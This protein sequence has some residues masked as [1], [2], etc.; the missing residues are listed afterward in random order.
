MVP[1]PALARQE[2]GW[3]RLWQP[4][5][6]RLILPAL[7]TVILFSLAIFAIILPA[8]EENSLE[9]KREMIRELVHT[10]CD[11]L[12]FYERL[13]QEG[14]LT[15]A[16]AQQQARELLRGQRYGQDLKD[17]FWINDLHPRMIMHPYRPDLEGADISTYSDPEGKR[18]FVEFVEVA[19]AQGQGYVGYMWQ[20]MD[21]PRRI[22][23]KISYVQLFQPW[24]WIVGTGIYV[25]DVAAEITAMMSK[26]TA[27]SLT[28]LVT[29]FLLSLYIIKHGLDTEARRQ[30]ALEDLSASRTML[31]LVIDN[32]PQYVF[33]QDG[34]YRYLGCNQ[35]YAR[36][37]GVDSPQAIK[38]Q[39]DFDLGW[40]LSAAHALRQADARAMEGGQAELRAPEQWTSPNGQRR[41]MEASRIPLHDAEGRVVGVLGSLEDVTERREMDE[42]LRQSEKRFRDLVE[43]SLVGICI[44]QAGRVVYRNPEFVA[45][46][47]DLPP[48]FTFADFRD[49]PPEDLARLAGLDVA[50]VAAQGGRVEFELRY[51]PYGR[52]PSGQGLRWAFC[53]ANLIDF[54]G[55]P[56]L[57]VIWLDITKAKEL[58]HL[59]GIQDKMASLGRV[60]AGLAH[61]IRNPL[62][63]INLYL[64]ALADLIDQP[65]RAADAQRVLANI[66]NASAKIEAVIKRVLDFSKP[67][68]PRM[69]WMNVGQ[70]V[71]EALELS[72]VTLRKAGISLER[73]LAPNLPLCYADRQL[74]G[75]VL[76]NLITNAVQAL[77]EHEGDKRLVVAAALEGDRLVI[78]VGD[79]GPGV[80]LELREKI[81]DPFFS[82]KR[83]G[84]GI[85]LSLSH[86]IVTDHG[87]ALKVGV[88]RWGGAEFRVEI[89]AIVYW[90][91]DSHG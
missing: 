83:E 77:R 13:H 81:F 68:T 15:L 35:N 47:G 79:S 9:R 89:P 21:D 87:G 82:I 17:Y 85:G 18:I 4:L 44:L 37:A 3:R 5:S 66:K 62:S 86:R 84:S 43:H 34:Q 29:I 76:L 14:K 70:V 10:A 49:A 58:E 42:A 30:Q 50:A 90:G 56:A 75:Q 26:L 78:S 28:I 40:G 22:V 7:L 33:W 67:S 25:E 27:V 41:W 12:A 88:S 61:E 1:D 53:R 57:L 16:Q 71:E 31:R 23:P 63:G 36:L 65:G 39:N 69:G 32:I 91:Y 74:I 11:S 64:S 45:L 80:P 73:D 38:G 59:L 19:K 51:F 60:A 52:M 72:A 46:L 20:W 24:G 55:S 54:Q 2:I 6:I 8:L 48:E